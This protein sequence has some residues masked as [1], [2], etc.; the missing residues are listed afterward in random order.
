MKMENKQL[1]K[2]EN[3]VDL[4]GNKDLEVLLTLG[5]GDI[6]EFVEPLK[7]MLKNR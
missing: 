4:L 3:L 2:K 5:A 7:K 1:A 6:G